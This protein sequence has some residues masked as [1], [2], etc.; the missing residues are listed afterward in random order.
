MPGLAD[1]LKQLQPSRIDFSCRDGFPQRAARLMRVMAI[2]EAAPAE[3][4]RELDKALFYP[5]EAEVMQA[6]RL[7]AGAVDQ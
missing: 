5:A 7:H 1:L 3:I 6:E 2:V 4:L